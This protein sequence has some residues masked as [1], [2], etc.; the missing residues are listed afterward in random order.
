M[1]KL[2]KDEKEVL[3]IYLNGHPLDEHYE[4]W[5]SNATAKSADFICREEG[6][7]LTE[8]DTVIV[9]GFFYCYFIN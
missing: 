1:S 3:G 8:G 7:A 5:I 6:V 9:G 2:L 4:Q